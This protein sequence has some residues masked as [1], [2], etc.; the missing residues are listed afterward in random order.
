MR[1]L[2]QMLA[3]K[4]RRRHELARLPIEDKVRAVVRLQAMAAPI[5]KQRGKNVRCCQIGA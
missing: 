2:S 5:L 1:D 4:E 3:G